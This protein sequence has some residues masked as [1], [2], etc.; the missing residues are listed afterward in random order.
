MTA[1][2][3]LVDSTVVVAIVAE[4]HEYHVASIALLDGP[5]RVLLAIAAHSYSEAYSTLTRRGEHAPFAFAAGEAWAALASLRAV[6][7]LVGLTAAQSFEAFGRYAGSDGVGPRLYDALI[8]SAA[9]LHGIS[10]IVTWNVGH[11][12]G[13]FPELEVVTPAMFVEA[14]GR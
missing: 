10:R 12:R 8:G 14:R 1:F 5:G 2:D 9:V 13:L 7:G 11:M 3:A 6:T 4:A